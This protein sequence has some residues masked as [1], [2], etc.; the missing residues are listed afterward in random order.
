MLLLGATSIVGWNLYQQYKNELIPVCNSHNANSK[1][2][3]WH[4]ADLENKSK[5]KK[6]IEQVKPNIIIHCGGICDID[7]CEENKQWANKINVK[8]IGLLLRTLPHESRLV[9]CSSDHVFSGDGSYTET[10]PPCP[11]THYGQ[12]RVEAENRIMNRWPNSIIIRYGLPIGPSFDGK[13]GHLDWLIYR[14]TV[15]VFS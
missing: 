1:C 12:T 2:A 15:F 14:A 3:S 4:R 10:S 13:S 9:Y 7:K 6:V 5:I 8:S 11:I